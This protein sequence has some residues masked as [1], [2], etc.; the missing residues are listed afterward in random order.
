[1]SSPPIEK[2][3][4]GFG[5]NPSRLR[6]RALPAVLAVAGLS[7]G[8]FVFASA[9]WREIVWNVSRV[10]AWFPLLIVLYTLAQAAFAL[11]WRAVIDPLPSWRQFPRLLAVYLAGDAANTLVPGNVAGEPLKVP[12]LRGMAAPEAALSSV[13]IHKHADL[14]AQWLFVCAGVGV[15]LTRFRLPLPASAGALAATGGLGLLLALMTWALQRGTYAPLLDRMARWKPLGRRLGRFRRPARAVDLRIR[16]FYRMHPRRFAAAVA[17]C[18]LGW[19]GGLLETRILLRLLTPHAGWAAAFAVEALA[20]TLNNVFLFVPGRIGTAEGIRVAV[21]VLLGLPAPQ[22]AAY[23]LL[24]RARELAWIL[25]GLVVLAG[26]SGR[27]AFGR[28]PGGAAPPRPAS[29]VASI[30]APESNP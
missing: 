4:S 12:L 8:V 11:G 18:F 2:P 22:G 15:A 25:P 13:T 23:A 3:R 24:R 5:S 29:L 27:A 1:M 17:W 16:D 21:F 26:A 28:G 7:L 20:M 9:G 6:S 30:P 19:C 14:L 10:G